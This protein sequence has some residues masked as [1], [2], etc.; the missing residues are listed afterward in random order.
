MVKIDF[1]TNAMLAQHSAE[2]E[3]ALNRRLSEQSEYFSRMLEQFTSLQS[4]LLAERDSELTQR[5]MRQLLDVLAE[6]DARI[7]S[8]PAQLVDSLASVTGLQVAPSEP[9]VLMMSVARCPE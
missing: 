2:R 9:Q 8:E 4:A 3:D 1:I 7:V 5:L 6:R